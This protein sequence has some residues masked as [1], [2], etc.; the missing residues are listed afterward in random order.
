MKNAKNNHQFTIWKKVDLAYSLCF[1]RIELTKTS[2]ITFLSQF[3]HCCTRGRESE[4]GK[5]K[6]SNWKNLYLSGGFSTASRAFLP[7]Q[8]AL[9]RTTQQSCLKP[10]SVY[11]P[12]WGY[13]S[14]LF[15]GVVEREPIKFNNNP[16]S[17]KICV[18]FNNAM[19]SRKVKVHL[20]C[21]F[22]SFFKHTNI[23]AC[24]SQC[25]LVK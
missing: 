25:K 3:N 2:D 7:L 4:K 9:C 13:C 20:N 15:P 10:C 23:L 11:H 17:V 21:V 24:K 18:Q 19:H 12:H 1:K 6:A 16:I 14:S 22:G 5:T 8:H